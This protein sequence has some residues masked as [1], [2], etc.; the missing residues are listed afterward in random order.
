MQRQKKKFDENEELKE[1][2]QKTV[3]DKVKEF[4]KTEAMRLLVFLLQMVICVW[5]SGS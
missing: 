4:D 1:M 2:L 3:T 5:F